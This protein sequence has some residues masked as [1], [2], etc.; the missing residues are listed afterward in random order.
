MKTFLPHRRTPYN[1]FREAVIYTFALVVPL[2]ALVRL[3]TFVN[4]QRHTAFYVWAWLSIGANSIVLLV[5]LLYST[6][7]VGGKRPASGSYCWRSFRIIETRAA[8]SEQLMIIGVLIFTF[9]LHRETLGSVT[10]SI[11]GIFMLA[12]A[13]RL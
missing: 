3:V 8:S 2:I 9:V 1:V 10:T 7:I 12:N 13:V 4:T 6:I 5:N 11:V